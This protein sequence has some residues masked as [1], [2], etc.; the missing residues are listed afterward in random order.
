MTWELSD[1]LKIGGVLGAVSTSYAIQK[2][3]IKVL[4]KKTDRHQ[5]TLFGS[6]KK[7]GLITDVQLT[8]LK[9]EQIDKKMDEHKTDLNWIKDHLR[10]GGKK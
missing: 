3:K 7:G 5:D 10:N 9:V 6:D 8:K 1:A 2:N 4:F